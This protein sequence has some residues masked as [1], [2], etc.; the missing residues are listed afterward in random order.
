MNL[1]A[2]LEQLIDLLD[3]LEDVDRPDALGQLEEAISANSDT[4]D[5]LVE[6]IRERQL[7][8]ATLAILIAPLSRRSDSEPATDLLIELLSYADSDVARRAANHMF[9]VAQASESAR[10]GLLSAAD[11]ITAERPKT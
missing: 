2:F 11:R 7:K 4:L 3:N 1:R 5:Y 8:P 6:I 9:N 10:N